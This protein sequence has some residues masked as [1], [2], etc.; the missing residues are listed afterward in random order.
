M[1][2]PVSPTLLEPG[3]AGLLEDYFNQLCEGQPGV[4]DAMVDRYGQLRPGWETLLGALEALGTDGRLQVTWVRRTRIGGD[5]WTGEDVPLGESAERYRVEVRKDGA[6]RRQTDVTLPHWSYDPAA[7]AL[8]GVAP[9]YRIAVA[10]ISS[11]FGPGP[12]TEIVIA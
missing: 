5:D 12:F 8:D 11:E 10:Q 4:F 9:P 6:V 2:A 1:T 7:Q 3:T